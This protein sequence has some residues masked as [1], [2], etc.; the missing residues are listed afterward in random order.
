[1]FTS[2]CSKNHFMVIL[3]QIFFDF[4]YF[5]FFSFPLLYSIG[6][7]VNVKIF[8]FL[9]F[10]VFHILECEES[11]KILQS[12]W[13]MKVKMVSFTCVQ[14]IKF[15]V[16]FVYSDA[17]FFD[18]L[19]TKFPFALCNYFSALPVMYISLLVIYLEISFP[20]TSS[21]SIFTLLDI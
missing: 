3:D 10:Q 18:D 20:S 7:W 21:F 14:T 17:Y 4:F 15:L 13:C 6:T 1:M 9:F 5:T 8:I 11:E 16:D 12:K 19:N 2:H